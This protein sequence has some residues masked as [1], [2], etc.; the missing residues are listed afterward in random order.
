MGNFFST[1]QLGRQEISTLEGD[2]PY[3]PLTEID[4]TASIRKRLEQQAS[5]ERARRI[6]ASQEGRLTT[7]RIVNPA[8][9]NDPLFGWQLPSRTQPVYVAA[10]NVGVA[11]VNARRTIQSNRRISLLADEEMVAVQKVAPLSPFLAEVTGDV[12]EVPANSLD[13][14]VERIILIFRPNDDQVIMLQADGTTYEESWNALLQSEDDR[15]QRAITLLQRDF[16]I[17]S[18][19]TSF[20]PGTKNTERFFNSS[21]LET[22]IQ[23]PVQAEVMDST[24]SQCISLT[25]V[26]QKHTL[27]DYQ[28]AWQQRGSLSID[29]P[30]ADSRATP[31]SNAR[32]AHFT[33]FS[34][35][36]YIDTGTPGLGTALPPMP[37]PQLVLPPTMLKMHRDNNC[38]PTA[39]RQ[40]NQY[41]SLG[42]QVRFFDSDNDDSE[43]AEDESSDE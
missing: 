18:I 22:T 7:V 43:V 10:N 5:P 15:D 35:S 1:N 33:S 32:S 20:R 21:T 27:R 6:E 4:G 16:P 13:E 29:N 28:L 42:S 8:E 9:F 41:T 3:Q 36:P 19:Y 11:T 2:L 38:S 37:P 25:L 26:R 23:P 34:Q 39:Q 31:S 30:A 14:Q 40:C 12:L 17:V 24:N